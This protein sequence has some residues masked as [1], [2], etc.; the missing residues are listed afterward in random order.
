M[1]RAAGWLGGALVALWLAAACFCWA[2]YVDEQ[3]RRDAELSQ[4]FEGEVA[5]E[6][7]AREE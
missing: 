3:E 1:R 2:R 7:A 5:A 4:Q 6:L